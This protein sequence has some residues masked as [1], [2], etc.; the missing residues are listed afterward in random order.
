MLENNG[1]LP[2]TGQQR[3]AVIGPTADDPLALLSGYSFPVHLIISDM[4]DSASQVVT[5]LQALQ[6]RVSSQNLRYAK[7]CHIIEHRVAGA[8]VFPGDS[9]VKPIQTSPVSR[10]TR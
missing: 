10:D 2:L 5:P 3:L 4:Q 1:V 6:E 8:P 7:G 9:G